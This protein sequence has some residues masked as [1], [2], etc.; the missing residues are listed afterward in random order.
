MEVSRGIRDG[1]RYGTTGL[2]D[3][4]AGCLPKNFPGLSIDLC[5]EFVARLWIAAEGLNGFLRG[6]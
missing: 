6:M 5:D 1:V 4:V 2:G 3:G